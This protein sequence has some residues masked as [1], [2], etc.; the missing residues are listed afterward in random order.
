MK[1]FWKRFLEII[2]VIGLFATFTLMIVDAFIV[3]NTIRALL[4]GIGGGNMVIYISYL[5][6][7]EWFSPEPSE[8]MKKYL[9]KIDKKK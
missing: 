8:G 2:L 3:S 1:Y 7:F 5:L 4:I 9:E 6:W